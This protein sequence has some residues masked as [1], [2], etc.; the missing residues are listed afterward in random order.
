MHNHKRL[1]HK[2]ASPVLEG[3]NSTTI[4]EEA[5]NDKPVG[6]ELVQANSIGEEPLKDNSAEVRLDLMNST[7]SLEV[8]NV[9]REVSQHQPLDLSSSSSNMVVLNHTEDMDF[10][11]RRPEPQPLS[12][13][14]IPDEFYPRQDTTYYSPQDTLNNNPQIG[15]IY[16]SQ[17]SR[18]HLPLYPSL[19]MSSS[20]SMNSPMCQP[21]PSYSRSSVPSVDTNYI[22]N[23][24]ISMFCINKQSI[25]LSNEGN[26]L[27]NL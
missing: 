19:G 1:V 18:F 7:S 15:N 8:G 13:G 5:I 17:D 4:E 12:V 21:Q 6:V 23:N 3:S 14:F 27:M 26:E 10:G 11:H 22:G 16:Y 25:I 2:K 24:S 20:L 9:N